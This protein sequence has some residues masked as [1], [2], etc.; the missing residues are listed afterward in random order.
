MQQVFM[1]TAAQLRTK[2]CAQGCHSRPSGVLMGSLVYRNSKVQAVLVACSDKTDSV[3]RGEGPTAPHPKGRP[4]A[5][6][7]QVHLYPYYC[8]C[9]GMACYCASVERGGGWGG[10]VAHLQQRLPQGQTP[11]LVQGRCTWAAAA[12]CAAWLKL[13]HL[14]FDYTDGTTTG[15]AEKPEHLPSPVCSRDIVNMMENDI[16]STA[17]LMWKYFL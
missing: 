1:K 5:S 7:K 4:K 10:G 9:P 16:L 3:A 6:F 15:T 17:L 13:Q 2:T 14:P 8:Y 12:P 11:W